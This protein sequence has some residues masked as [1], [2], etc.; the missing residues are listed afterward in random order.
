[1][2]AQYSIEST[3]GSFDLH[4]QEFSTIGFSIQLPE[5]LEE[6]SVEELRQR[7]PPAQLPVSA[8]VNREYGITF[9][10]F[11]VTLEMLDIEIADEAV[12]EI[13][14]VQKKTISRLTPGYHEY[15]AKSKVIDGHTIACLNYKS[16]SLDDD[17]YNIY[18]LFTQRNK[19]VQGSFSCL[20]AD[21]V[22]WNLVFLMCLNTL[23]FTD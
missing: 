11:P 7:F 21:Q 16:N 3:K 5:L 9:T 10:I 17:L 18:F 8:K 4:R 22:E 6:L 1:M 15:G 19:L 14:L 23:K 12:T 20:L 13:M 2:N